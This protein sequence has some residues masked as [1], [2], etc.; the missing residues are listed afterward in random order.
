MGCGD[1]AGGYSFGALNVKTG[2]VRPKEILLQRKRDKE[3]NV[4]SEQRQEK[5]QRVRMSLFSVCW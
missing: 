5:T 2:V 3:T 4:Q 1:H